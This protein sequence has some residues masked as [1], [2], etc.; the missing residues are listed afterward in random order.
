MCFELSGAKVTHA[1]KSLDII[2]FVI[3]FKLLKIMIN[4]FTYP[5][6]FNCLN[7]PLHKVHKGVW[8]IEDVLIVTC[9]H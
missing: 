9:I 1:N 5:D 6:Y 8:I 4:Y 7:V 3:F 2:I